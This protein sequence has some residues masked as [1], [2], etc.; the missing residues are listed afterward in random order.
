MDVVKEGKG[1]YPGGLDQAA[2][3]AEARQRFNEGVDADRENRDAGLDDLKFVSGEQWDAT[4]KAER[5]RRGQPCL[6]I[7][8][9]PQYIGQVIGDIR[10]N[11]PSIRVRP[12]EDGD[13]KIAEIR[14]GLI[15]HI[16]NNC[17]AHQVYSL[18]GEDQV[19][20]GLGHFRVGLEYA[21]DDSFDQDIKLSHIPN[22]FSVVW[23]SMSV[24]P[25]GADARFCFVVDEIDRK[26]F[27]K[28][29][30]DSQTSDLTVPADSVGW[31]TRDSVRLTEYWTM[32]E[33]KRRIALVQMAP[34]ASPAMRDVT[35]NEAEMTPFIVAGPDGQP[36]VRDTIRKTACMY[37]INGHE[38][39][40]GPYE[41]PIRRL[42]V[43]RVTGRE[44][45]VADR[46][47]RFGLV[48]FA[49]D[50][51]RMK[52]LMRS[53]AMEWVAKAPKAQWLLHASDE[54]E[55][56]R[57]R[58]SGKSGDTVLTY[59]GQIPP[60]RIDP[61]SSPS[62]LLQEAQFNDQDIKDVTG[63]HDASLGM[64]SNETSG[65]AIMARER[66][67]DVA[68]F[69]YH[70]NL[71]ASIREAGRV[72][73]DL[74]P[75]VFDTART[76][77]VIGDDDAANLVQINDPNNPEAVDLKIGKYDIVVET[78]PSYSTKRVEAAESMTAFFQAVPAAAQ[79]AGDLFAQ[80]QDWPMADEIAERL[81]GALPPGLVKPK[82][83]EQPSEAEQQQMQAQAQAQQVQQQQAEEARQIA[84]AQAMADLETKRA[85]AALKMAQAQKMVTPE[86]GQPMPDALDYA[87]KEQQVRK[88]IADADKAE[89]EAEKARADAAMK[90][91]ESLNRAADLEA[92]INP[93][94][95]QEAV[96]A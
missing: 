86:P 22:P 67:G 79:V 15:R 32:K 26:V 25:T 5:Q 39:L 93:P 57:Y 35:D 10:T 85:E 74:I 76:I 78:G 9:L 41:L 23:D 65:R 12:A 45:R 53:A 83:G 55:A 11:R 54:K 52:N 62:A 17:N 14:Q 95:P 68:T 6:T 56:D 24:E 46:R 8:T 71:N 38:V 2:F 18:A 63:L 90:P 59:S 29:Y 88:A 61:P 58:K 94:Q 48:R 66:Q 89:A 20:C 3:L 27:E 84:M 64:K 31:V 70:D 43:F 34:E 60:Q 96:A 49:K 42:P 91:L 30:P 1:K 82:E 80:A 19:A 33:T 81:K 16:E 75:V 69:M 7:N 13:K 4:I 40:E 21:G 37:L 28:A 72:I 50:S 87:L 51:A 73:N 77:V 44:I 92:K 47:Y 36:R